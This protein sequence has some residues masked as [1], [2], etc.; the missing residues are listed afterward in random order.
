M[1]SRVDDA[2]TPNGTITV[3][4]ATFRYDAEISGRTNDVYK[5]VPVSQ[6]RRKLLA[7]ADEKTKVW[8]LS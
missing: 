3:H 4:E 7:T 8:T 2:G 5:F 6:L 1:F